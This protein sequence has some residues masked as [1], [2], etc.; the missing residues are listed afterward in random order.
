MLRSIIPL[1]A[2]ICLSQFIAPMLMVVVDEKEKKIKESLRMVGLRDSV[3]W[4]S[5][6]FVYSLMV[7]VIALVGTFILKFIVIRTTDFLALFLIMLIYGF[8]V[9]MFAFMLTALF[10]KAKV[11]RT[12]NIRNALGAKGF[13]VV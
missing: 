10:N 6:F 11:A 8:S 3:F 12:C 7:V 13:D 9:I 2:I 1:Y 4:L 5:W